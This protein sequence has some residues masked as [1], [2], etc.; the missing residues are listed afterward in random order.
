MI[1]WSPG[2]TITKSR[3][4]IM[5]KIYLI[6]WVS[7]TLLLHYLAKAQ[8]DDIPITSDNT[9]NSVLKAKKNRDIMNG[10]TFR[11]P[12]FDVSSSLLV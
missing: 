6:L 5:R 12:A 3:I 4:I 11:M 9:N 7:L 10:L 1:H 8:N 2:G